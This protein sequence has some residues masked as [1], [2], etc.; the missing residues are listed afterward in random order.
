M[1][2]NVLSQDME[3]VHERFLGFESFFH[4]H[5]S[6]EDIS[7]FPFIRDSLK[8]EKEAKFLMSEHKGLLEKLNE[9]KEI[10]QELSLVNFKGPTFALLQLLQLCQELLLKHLEDEEKIVID[11]I[12]VHGWKGVI[13]Q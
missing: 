11:I 7:L 13:D 5:A 9:A 6:I 2:S 1:I 12:L 4:A 3:A 10:L 8:M